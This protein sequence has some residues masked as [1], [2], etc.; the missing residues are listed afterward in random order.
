MIVN[1]VYM[2]SRYPGE[3]GL[4]SDGILSDQQTKEFLEYAKEIKAIILK[5]L[6]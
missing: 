3:L 1:E 4:V 5:E 6:N 2:E